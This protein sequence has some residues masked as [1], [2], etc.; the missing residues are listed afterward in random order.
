MPNLIGNVLPN[1]QSLN[2]AQRCPRL[3][4]LMAEKDLHMMNTH[5]QPVMC[6]SKCACL[7]LAWPSIITT[8]FPSPSH[9]R[10]IPTHLACESEVTGSSLLLLL[11]LRLSPRHRVH[12][13]VCAFAKA[14][15]QQ[16]PKW[17][18]T[19]HL[20]PPVACSGMAA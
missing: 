16:Q 10:S 4:R 2:Y 17:N 19:P 12:L 7:L 5:H 6:I 3:F 1:Q 20:T 14:P 9:S 13:R 15:T 18:P 8:P 11:L